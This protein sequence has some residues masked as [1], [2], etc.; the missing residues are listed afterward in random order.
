[1]MIC[2]LRGQILVCIDTNA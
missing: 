2:R 1:M